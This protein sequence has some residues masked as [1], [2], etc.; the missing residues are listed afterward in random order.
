MERRDFLKG[1]AG[2]GVAGAAGVGGV[3]ASAA[4]GWADWAQVRR[5]DRGRG[6]SILDRP[7]DAAPVTHVVVLMMENRSADHRLGWLATDDAYLDAGRRRYGRGFR[8][9]GSVDRH[10][11]DPDGDLVATWHLPSDPDEPSPYRGCGYT[12]PSQGWDEGRVQRDRGFLAEGSGNDPFALSYFLADDQPFY[13]GMARRFTVFDRSHCSLMSS[14]MPNRSYMHAAQ[15]LAKTNLDSARLP[16]EVR[17]AIPTIWDRLQAAGVP[18]GYYFH[19]WAV[20]TF[21]G[22][23][24]AP[25]THPAADYFADC[26]A[27]TLPNVTYVDPAFVGF[28]PDSNDDHPF[29]DI[30]AGQEFARDVF[31]AFAESPHWEHGAFVLTYDEWGGFFD[32]RPPPVLHDPRASHVDSENYGQ[33][34]FRVPT[35]LASPFARPGFVDHALYDHTSILRFLEWRYLG[36][37]PTGPGR[38]RGGRWWLTERDRFAG[39]LG[40]SLR[41]E[42]PDP[43]LGFDVGFDLDVSAPC[44][45]AAGP[46]P[47]P[48]ASGP[49]AAGPVA[50]T[51]SMG[52]A[53]PG[54]GG[55]P[56]DGPANSLSAVAALLDARA[57]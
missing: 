18:V 50:S 1:A 38:G 57:G 7:A 23:R 28:G 14:T 27:G 41:G 3:L 37:P 43:E 51:A 44:A 13:E 31:R 6:G 33:A 46:G 34:G 47:G 39:N 36:A 20:T 42:G 19:N 26:A 22:S 8:F 53:G 10:Y 35:F 24:L 21:F 17:A 16:L 5:P 52:A 30:R 25:V 54:A 32:H 55:R 15:S 48:A 49:V 9:A 45:P 40:T 12:D 2:A 29:A 4:P 56:A 11:A